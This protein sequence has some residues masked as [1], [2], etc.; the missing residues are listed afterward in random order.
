M[1]IKNNT[2]LTDI[3]KYKN[4]IFSDI[5]YGQIFYDDKNMEYMKLRNNLA[6]DNECNIVRFLSTD[7]FLIEETENKLI[8]V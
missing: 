6:E 2:L 1:D 4:I 3:K 5:K 8:N 7:I